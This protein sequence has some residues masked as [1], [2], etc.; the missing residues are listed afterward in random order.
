MDK[1][2]TKQSHGVEGEPD[3]AGLKEPV[4]FWD[5]SDREYLVARK[6]RHCCHIM[7][8]CIYKSRGM[9]RECCT[10]NTD[11]LHLTYSSIVGGTS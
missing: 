4:G 11:S 2:S 1:K 3:E 8:D 7:P 10:Y 9:L 5:N 6:I